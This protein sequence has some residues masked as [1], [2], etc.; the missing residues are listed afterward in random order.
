MNIPV[1]KSCDEDAPKLEIFT[2]IDFW[3]SVAERWRREKSPDTWI[4]KCQKCGQA[5]ILS[6]T[7]C[8]ALYLLLTGFLTGIT[9]FPGKTLTMMLVKYGLAI[10]CLPLPFCIVWND[11][12]WKK[13]PEDIFEK[14][15]KGLLGYY[16]ATLATFLTSMSICI[17]YYSA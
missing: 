7:Q 2:W 17:W 11:L 12:P 4:L 13:A 9:L 14:K 6:V 1:C 15:W 5:Y 8:V 10:L 3:R 16:I